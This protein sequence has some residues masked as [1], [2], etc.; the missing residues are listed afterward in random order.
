MH[1]DRRHC[2][3]VGTAGYILTKNALCNLATKR[4][5][6]G[7]FVWDSSQ[8]FRNI[9]ATLRAQGVNCGVSEPSSTHFASA[10]PLC[11]TDV[12]AYSST[13]MFGNLQSCEPQYASLKG[14]R[15][16]HYVDSKAVAFAEH[17]NPVTGSVLRIYAESQEKNICNTTS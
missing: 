2:D 10:F 7:K 13:I 16:S 8:S 4:Q 9:L 5:A 12:G 1:H 11:P 6:N 3:R 15:G 14:L 17:V